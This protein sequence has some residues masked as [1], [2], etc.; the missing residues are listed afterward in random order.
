MAHLARADTFAAALTL[1]G[2]VFPQHPERVIEGI[3]RRMPPLSLRSLERNGFETGSVFP[4]V[5]RVV[6]AMTPLIEDIVE[7]LEA[8]AGWAPRRWPA[9]AAARRA[10]GERRQGPVP[11]VS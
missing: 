9:V 3:I 2:T 10:Y 7:P 8:L 4:Y 6:Y 5:L 11:Q 1:P